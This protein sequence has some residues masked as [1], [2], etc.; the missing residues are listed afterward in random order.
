MALS[1]QDGSLWQF[2][3]G[4]GVLGFVGST[5]IGYSKV[6]GA[7]F[8]KH[9]GKA[10][11]IFGVES[12]IA[13]AFAPKLIQFLIDGYGWRG[14]FIGLG[15]IILAVIPL[16]LVWLKEPETPPAPEAPAG[17]PAE[18]PG[19]TPQQA[20]K[21]RDFWF[22]LIAGV[23]ALAP[24]MGLQPHLVPYF[25]SRGISVD[26]AVWMFSITQLAMAAGTVA[27]GFLMDRFETAKVAAP[28]SVLTAIGL[29]FYLF[30]AG[31]AMGFTF[32]LLATTFIGFAGGAKRPMATVFQLRF[33]GLKSFATLV[34]I[35][36]PFQA[37]C[38]GISPLLVG[39][40][41]DKYGRYEPV[42]VVMSVL[43]AIT[44]FLF[45][46]LGPFR[47][48]KNLTAIATAKADSQT[49][50]GAMTGASAAMKQGAE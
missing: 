20:L 10:L 26:T 3:T 38:M 15:L 23:I 6:I 30:L 21:T 9:R 43:M 44:F 48:A 47:Y 50:V 39:M 5:A 12:S 24:A 8:N 32:L 1:L 35:Q 7:L 29:A 45:W 19:L 28:F 13:G 14:M 42:F 33:F 16:L 11:A 40:Y 2:Y 49:P 27:G 17:A 36:A 25:V 37:A 41:Y 34:G 18:P 4:F 31:G 22:I 46:W